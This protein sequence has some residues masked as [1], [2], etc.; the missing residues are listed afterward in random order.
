VQEAQGKASLINRN[1]LREA[2]F[3]F[4][5]EPSLTKN[6][7]ASQEYVETLG[8]EDTFLYQYRQEKLYLTW[9]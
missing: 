7:S 6:I 3:I 2:G 4:S 8:E 9:S 5:A 1:R